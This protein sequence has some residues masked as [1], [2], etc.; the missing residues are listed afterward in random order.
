MTPFIHIQRNP[1]EEPHHLNLVMTASNGGV[2]GRLEFYLNA[3]ALL[4]WAEGVESFPLH[5]RSVLRWEL[6][7]EYPDDRFGFYFRLRLFTVDS[8]GHSAI[9]LRFNNNAALPE[10]EISE[11]CIP[12]EP[13]QLNRLGRLLREFAQLQHRVLWWT[14]TNGSLFVTVQD[15]E[16]ALGGDAWKPTRASS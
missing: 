12:S 10:R 2:Q 16:Q 8:V 13:A 9:Q 1:Y 3:D 11:F 7:S 5:A 4:E 15:A 6:G 14:P